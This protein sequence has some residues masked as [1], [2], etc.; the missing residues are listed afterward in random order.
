MPKPLTLTLSSSQRQELEHARDHHERPY[1]RERA[2]AL[3]KIAQGLTAHQVALHGLLKTRDPDTVYGW[4]RRYLAEGMPGLLVRAGRGRKPA[5]SPSA[6]FR[7]E[8]QGSPAARGPEGPPAPG[9]CAKP[10]DT[11]SPCPDL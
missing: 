3:L 8:R 2:A 1:V 11:G 9:A 7:A 5:F 6:R 10:V 4:L